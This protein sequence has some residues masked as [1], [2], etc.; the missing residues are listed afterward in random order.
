MPIVVSCPLAINIFRMR[1]RETSWPRSK[2]GEERLERRLVMSWRSI[3]FGER[4]RNV[5]EHIECGDWLLLCWLCR[6]P[7]PH[8]NPHCLHGLPGSSWPRLQSGFTLP[9]DRFD[10]ALLFSCSPACVSFIR[11]LFLCFFFYCILSSF[12]AFFLGQPIVCMIEE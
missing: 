2:R 4:S 5:P 8:L 10:P 6:L 11:P 9:P 7:R 12:S 3:P 1:N